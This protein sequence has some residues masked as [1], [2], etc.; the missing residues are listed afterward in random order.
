MLGHY[1]IRGCRNG[2]AIIDLFPQSYQSLPEVLLSLVCAY[3]SLVR[4]H[5][6]ISDLT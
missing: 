4:K 5:P 2:E 1:L 6:N 3:V